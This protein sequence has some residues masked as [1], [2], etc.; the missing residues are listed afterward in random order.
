MAYRRILVTLDGSKLAETALDAAL[1]VASPS[2]NI[3][4]LSVMAVGPVSEMAEMA[5]A[6][7]EPPAMGEPSWPPIPPPEDPRAAHAREDYLNRVAD[8]LQQAGYH[9]TTEVRP[10]SVIDTIVSV[11]RDGFEIIVMASHGRTG[12]AR[13]AIGS[14]A[15]GVLHQS[16]CPMLI[17]PARALQQ[18]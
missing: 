12:I 3:H 8:W 2:A 17:I 7:A 14:I 16:P 10:G 15:E 9:V 11:A 5:R 1:Q 18:P 13:I 4:L 6:V